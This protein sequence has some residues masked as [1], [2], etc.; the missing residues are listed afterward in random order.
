MTI[1]GQNKYIHVGLGTGGWGG[2]GLS[3]IFWWG[4]KYF[5]ASHVIVEDVEK[6]KNAHICKDMRQKYRKIMVLWH[7]S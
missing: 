4:L 3:Y 2:L 1:S 5:S 6:N 7:V